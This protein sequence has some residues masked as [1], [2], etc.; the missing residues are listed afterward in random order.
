[1]RIVHVVPQ[2]AQEASG[3]SYSVPRL[4]QAIAECG[5]QVELKCIAAS[6]AL[7]GVQVSTYP[8]WRALQRFEVSTALARSLKQAAREV[9][10][11]HNHSLWSMVNVASGCIVPGHKAKLVTSPRGT[12]SSW[13]L[14]HSRYRKRALWPLQKKALVRADLLHATSY[15]EYQEIR[16]LGL[17]APV[18]VIP[19]GID[20]PPPRPT[21]R[22]GS[23]RTVLFLSRIHPKKGIDNL[24]HAWKPLEARHPEWR[25]VIAGTGE[26]QHVADVHELAQSLGV[27]RV[28]FPGPLYGDTKHD[29]YYNADLFVLPTHS[30]N[31]GMVVAEALA[32]GCPAIVTRGA[33]WRDLETEACGWWIDDDASALGEALD[34]AMRLTQGQLAVMGSKGRDWMT[35]VFGWSTI[36]TSMSAAYRW[37]IDGG[38][39][40]SCVQ[41]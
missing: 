21:V 18:A 30:E 41:E 23:T 14:N 2:I 11:I 4:C 35:R 13:A 31:F 37:L 28:I 20:L 25:L 7:P 15:T 24:L 33:P 10:I 9:D 32:H 16:A 6:G 17:R 34:T 36:G 19:N 1:M 8:Q 40:P 5:N 38:E 3:P 27:Q 29:A 26:P 12:L 22:D 39:A